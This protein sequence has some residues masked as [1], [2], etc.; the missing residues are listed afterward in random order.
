MGLY[1]QIVSATISVG[2]D[3]IAT[4]SCHLLSYKGISCKHLICMLTSIGVTTISNYM[5]LDRWKINNFESDVQPDPNTSDESRELNL[6]ITRCSNISRISQEANE[7]VKNELRNV[8]AKLETKF[9]VFIDKPTNDS[10][11]RFVERSNW[12]TV[13]ENPKFAKTKGSGK[14]TGRPGKA[15]SRF[16]SYRKIIIPKIKCCSTCIEN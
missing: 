15:D 3:N 8:I 12:V 11:S 5:I 14:N 6:L 1:T 16:K 2:I 13:I 7:E 4:C 10:I 9:G